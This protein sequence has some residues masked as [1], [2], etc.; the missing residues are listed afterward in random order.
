M[1]CAYCTFSIYHMDNKEEGSWCLYASSTTTWRGTLTV[2]WNEEPN[3]ILHAGS[4]DFTEWHQRIGKRTSDVFEWGIVLLT[5]LS[6]VY[7]HKL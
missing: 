6:I 7:K 2:S 1:I 3:T 4:Q 5:Q